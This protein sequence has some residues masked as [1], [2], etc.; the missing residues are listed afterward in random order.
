MSGEKV[1]IIDDSEALRSLLESIL[2]FGGYE[3]ICAGTGEQGLRLVLEVQPDVIMTD[4][5]LPDITGL[6][7]LE[8]LNRQGVA[9]PTIM[10]TAYGSEGVAA[11]ALKLGV[12]DYL[13]KP[14]TTEEVLD[15]IER[16]LSESRLQGEKERLLAL[17]KDYVYHFRL[18]G[19]VGRFVTSDLS[20]DH[21]L[22]R[23]VEACRFVT[24]AETG[25][26]LL[27]DEASEQLQVMASQGQG[28]YAGKRYSSLAG[29]KE[30]HPVLKEQVIVRFYSSPNSTLELQTG[31]R[32]KAV[33]QVPLKGSSQSW[34]LLSV[35]RRVNGIPFDKHDEQ[36]MTILADYVVM[37]LEKDRH[38]AM[39]DSTQS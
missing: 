30:L 38:Q 33:L 22:Q 25:L 4:L 12:R 27:V 7:L 8:E 1:L 16:V 17:L 26:L 21:L 6:E 5:E 18:L 39:L 23:I 2:P 20:L 28:N 19:I 13:V 9:I 35:D 10:M 36:M 29:A 15:A 31:D 34:G 24:R 37:A 3:A 32:V 11:Q 14:F